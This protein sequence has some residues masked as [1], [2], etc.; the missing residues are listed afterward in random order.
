MFLQRCLKL[1]YTWHILSGIPSETRD[2]INS[3][4]CHFTFL[5]SNHLSLYSSGVFPQVKGVFLFLSGK[6]AFTH[7]KKK[8]AKCFIHRNKSTFHRPFCQWCVRVICEL[9]RH[10]LLPKSCGLIWSQVTWSFRLNHSWWEAWGQGCRF[11]FKTKWKQRPY[12][13]F[14][15]SCM[16]VVMTTKVLVWEPRL[17]SN[18]QKQRTVGGHPLEESGL[19]HPSLYFKELPK[20]TCGSRHFLHATLSN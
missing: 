2:I 7:I 11:K 14:L 16:R 1:N 15:R 13:S 20:G 9:A 5:I 3:W 19:T 17:L 18:S 4:G 6:Q 10:V 12:S 8:R